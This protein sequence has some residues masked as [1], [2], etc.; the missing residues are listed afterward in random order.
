MLPVLGVGDTEL[1]AA[2]GCGCFPSCGHLACTHPR[3]G[4]GGISVLLYCW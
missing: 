1:L 4:W 3:I 2:P